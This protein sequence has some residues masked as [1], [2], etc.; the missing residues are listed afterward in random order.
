MSYHSKTSKQTLAELDT[1]IDGLTKTAVAERLQQ[2]GPNTISVRAEP[3]WHRIIEPFMSVFMLVLFGAAAISFLHHA[4]IDGII[5]VAIILI[6]AVID[7]VQ[8]ISTE[9]IL[10]SLRKRTTLE[11]RVLRREGEVTIDANNLVPGDIVLLEEGDKVPADGR[12]LEARSFRVDE[13]QLTGESLPIEKTSSQVV[14]DAAIYERTNSVYQGSFVIGGTATVVVTNTGNTTEYGKLAALSVAPGET[15]PV[16]KK[17]DQ[18]ISKIIVAILAIAIVVF[19]LAVYR[20]MDIGDALQFV[21]ALSVSAVPE[22]LPVAISV[23]LAIGMKRMAARKALVRSMSAIETIGAI[24]TIATDKTGTLTKNKLTVREAWHPDQNQKTLLNTLA[25]STLPHTHSKS[26]DPLDTA[27]NAYCDDQHVIRDRTTPVTVFSFEH[28][29]SMSGT[30]WHSG[31]QYQLFV[32]GAPEQI[33]DH[34]DLTEAERERIYA[35]LHH[36]TGLGY[37]VIALAHTTLKDSLASLDK[38]SQK[39][40]LTFDGLVGIA[41]ILRPEAKAAIAKAQRAGIVVRMITGDHFETAYHIGKELGLVNSSSEVFDSRQITSMSDEDLS[42][43]VEKSRVFSRVIPEHKH[44]IL[45]ILKQ[46]NIT[47]MT[48][49]GV[50]DVPALTNAHVGLAMGSGVQIAKD[51]GDIILIDDNFRSIINAVHEGRTILA[52]IKRMVVYLLS[53][54]L[55]EVLV[56]LGAL[57]AGVPVP[58]MPVQILWVNL[59]TDTTMVI[60]LGLEPGEKRNMNRPPQK[61]NAALLSKFMITRIGLIAVV[62]AVVTLGLYA[63]YSARY[64]YEYARTIAFC[65][66]VVMQWASALC[67]RSDYESVFRRIFRWSKTFYVGLFASILLQFIAVF[68]PLGEMLHVTVISYGD[69]IFTS[70]IAFVIPIIFIELHKWIGRKFFNKGSENLRKQQRRA[71]RVRRQHASRD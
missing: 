57:I 19:V 27:F 15:S 32:K 44:R 55:G 36:M 45:T 63:V 21:I 52:N 42:E 7:Y 29:V 6:S 38:L 70:V 65:A 17:I 46:H 47:A 62:M 26:Y 43:A 24:T 2:Y 60:P 37:R 58:L 35:Q 68:G 12:V 13:S 20:G 69:L 3:L 18:L 28:T 4:F 64:G 56:S 53:T 34:S 48:G 10:R 51:A 30:L 71:A 67:A 11:V 61:A 50:N 23:V 41:D 25:K 9:R 1:T 16:Q 66:L 59:V 49:D 14:A 54:N 40:R 31:N 22:G 8:Q 33:T 39:Q 5:I